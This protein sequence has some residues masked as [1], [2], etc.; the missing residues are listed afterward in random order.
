MHSDQ[1]HDRSRPL[2]SYRIL[3]FRVKPEL[4]RDV[5]E[6]ASERGESLATT[7]RQA[8]RNEVERRSER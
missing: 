1:P 7:V 8:L 2:P 3:N 6:I 5:R 4:Y